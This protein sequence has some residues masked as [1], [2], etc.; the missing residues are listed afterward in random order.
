LN[1]ALGLRVTVLTD[2][3]RAVDV[4]PGDG[5]RAI[6]AFSTTDEVDPLD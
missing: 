2:A 3:V 4:S 6:A 5:D 1:L